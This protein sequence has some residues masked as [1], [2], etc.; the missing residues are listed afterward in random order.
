MAMDQLVEGQAEAA[1]QVNENFV[2]VEP[3]SCY[4]RK[5]STTNLLTWGYYGGNVML[6]GTLT[7]IADGTVS[8]T[9]SQTNYVQASNTTGAVSVNTTGFTDNYIQLYTVVTDGTTV[10]SYTDKRFNYGIFANNSIDLPVFMGARV[11]KSAIL[12]GQNITTATLVTFDSELFDT[13]GFHSTSVNTGR[14]TVPSGLG[15]EK[16]ILSGQAWIGSGASATGVAVYLY[17]NGARYDVGTTLAFGATT[18]MDNSIV[19]SSGPVPATDGDYFE[20]YARVTGDTSVDIKA[21][22]WFAIHVAEATRLD[23]HRSLFQT[24]ASASGTLTVDVTSY[25]Y[26]E[27][28]LTENVSTVTMAGVT[29]GVLN[30]FEL[31]VAQDGTGGRTWSNPASWKFPGGAAY[32]PSAAANAV[33]ILRGRTYDDGTTWEVEFQKGYA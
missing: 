9:A 14:L 8:L 5:A 25:E 17:K 7:V 19:F 22:S 26:F 1:T 27:T 18:A 32:T 3:A 20:I 6:D 11:Y 12:A 16:V 13:H 24:I 23:Q 4:G 2:A 10:T 21:D 29:T 30:R 31:R 15:I 28:T 33:D